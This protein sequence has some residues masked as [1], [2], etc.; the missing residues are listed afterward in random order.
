MTLRSDLREP[1]DPATNRSHPPPIGTWTIDPAD[2]SVT[3]AWRK[4][5][6]WTITGRR[7]CLGVIHLDELP[8]VGVIRFQQPSGLPVLTMAL[9]PASLETQDADLDA[10]LCGPEAVDVL[11]HRWWTLRSESLEI[12]PGGTWRVMATL[13]A[14]GTQ[15]LVELRLEVDP[16]ASGLDWLVLRGHGVLDRR[17]FRMGKRASILGPTIQLDLT[18]RARQVE[19]Q[20][21]RRP[22]RG[23]G[24]MH[25]QH[26]G[27]SQLLAEQRITQRHEQATHARLIR[28]A[29]PPR[30]R[31]RSPAA[32]GWWQLARWPAVVTQ[33]SVARTASVDRSEAP[34]SKFARALI[35]AATMAAMNLAGMAAVA[36]AQANDE[37]T[38]SQQEVAENWNYY[39]QATRVPPAELK[40]RMQADATQRRLSENWTY[41]YHATRMPPAQLK[42]WMQ[43]QDRADTP[44]EPPAQVPAPVR[45]PEPSGQPAWL[46]VSLGGLA[47]AMTLVAGLAVLSARRA[48][49]R[50]QVGHAA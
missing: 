42:A 19:T 47:A 27:L 24:H 38:T 44:T 22:A 17:A 39:Q 16:E 50:A 46:V 15:G 31:R 5:R 40:A 49:R 37:N 3:L 23:E 1:A 14:N 26:A 41:Y 20:R 9:D 36:H 30:R 4:L 10:M 6:F 45:P 32:R 8:P 2:S 13:T 28:G 25:N 21:H 35:L 48:S 29:H 11:R 12:L 7:P 43:A 33:K 34:M 18:V